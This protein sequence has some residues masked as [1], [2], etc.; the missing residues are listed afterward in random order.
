M[1]S[2]T[3]FAGKDRFGCTDPV[4]LVSRLE[5]V[6]S[7][8]MNKGVRMFH[9]REVLTGY[10]YKELYDWDLYFETLFLSYAGIDI[11]CRNNVEMFLDTQE[12]SGFIPRTM[13]IVYPKPRHHFK[14]FLAQTAL[15]GSRQNGDFRWL[16]GKYYE[17]LKKY[18][19]YWFWHCDADKNGLCFWD[20]SDHS[21]MDNQE[22][23]LGFIGQM[24]FEGVDLNCYLVRE[25]DAMAEIATELGI[26]QEARS[27][28]KQA[29]DLV[30][31][32]DATFWDEETGFYYD[33]SEKTGELNKLLTVSGFLPLW[34]GRIPKDRAER[35]VR[36]HLLNPE[37]FWLPYPVATW[38]KSEAGYYQ[39]RKDMECNWMGPTWIPVNYMIFHGLLKHGFQKEAQLLAQKTYEL[40]ISE[41]ETREYYDGETGSGQGLCPFWGWS[42]LGYVMPLEYTLGYDPSDKENRVFIIL[43]EL[44]KNQGRINC[45][46]C[47]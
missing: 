20:G 14:P 35:L 34:L 3:D 29:A 24:E 22:P 21:G 26:E 9:G 36:E 41:G 47:T 23:R 27:F 40:V 18:L 32:I 25:L 44:S 4:Y 11:Y 42:T 8:I 6:K 7:D 17:R 15:L 19:E 37:E 43:E 1:K 2:I 16:Q 31:K 28:E 13:G 38:A 33:R 46:E 30:S 12:P 5:K 45:E 39:Q 10:A